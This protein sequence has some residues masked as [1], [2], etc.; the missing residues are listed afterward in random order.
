MP[1]NKLHDLK[2]DY[3]KSTLKIMNERASLICSQEL[4]EIRPQFGFDRAIVNGGEGFTIP[5]I[6]SFSLYLC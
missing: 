4:V 5:K 1:E 2:E 6:T 3:A